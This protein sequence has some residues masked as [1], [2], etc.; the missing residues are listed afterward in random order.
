MFQAGDEPIPGYRLQ[1]LLGGGQFG[2]V[3]KARGPGG[4]PVALKFIGLK[5]GSGFKEYRGIQRVLPLRHP[6]LVPMT[7]IFLL[8]QDGNVLDDVALQQLLDDAGRQPDDDAHLRRTG[9]AG[10]LEFPRRRAVMLVVAMALGDKT[11]ADRLEE[12]QRQLTTGLT[13]QR[14]ERRLRQLIAEGRA[15][16]PLPELLGYMDEAAKGIDFL[17]TH[18]HELGDGTVGTIQ[19]CDIKPANIMLAGGSAQVCDFGLA[20]ELTTS[21]DSDIRRTQS[22]IAGSPLYMAPECIADPDPSHATD[23]YSLAITYYELRTGDIPFDENVMRPKMAVLTAHAQGKLSF[24]KLPDAERQVLVRATSIDPEDRYRSARK[25]VRELRKAVK[26]ST[27][28]DENDSVTPGDVEACLDDAF[29]DLIGT[30]AETVESDAD[31][32]LE[33]DPSDNVKSTIRPADV[34]LGETQVPTSGTVMLSHLRRRPWV[35][36]PKRR[37][38]LTWPVGAILASVVVLVILLSS[39]P[40]GIPFAVQVIGLFTAGLFALGVVG[41]ISVVTTR[42]VIAFVTSTRARGRRAP[43]PSDDSVRREEAPAPLLHEANAVADR[44][45]A[46]EPGVEMSS[47]TRIL[48]PY[49]LDRPISRGRMAVVYLGRRIG[50]ES[51]LGDQSFSRRRLQTSRA[52]PPVL[53][54]SPHWR[55]R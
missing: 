4:P 8:D 45:A 37:R 44:L 28:Y 54:R 12:C 14:R 24:S 51:P 48:G 30:L 52:N 38:R 36:E 27:G 3:W 46:R 53:L 5:G 21:G 32:V 40:P 47:T 41:L 19:H 6:H 11:L 35:S 42:T 22:G 1:K 39:F 13:G 7:A 25:F 29:P 33:S 2:A 34:S 16:I 17:N 20:R 26:A 55:N 10:A 50:E 18:E 9:D 43:I 15:G 49:E 23:E 31:I